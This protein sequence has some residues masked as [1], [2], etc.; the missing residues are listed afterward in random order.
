MLTIFLLDYK[1]N[2]IY[3]YGEVPVKFHCMI[4]TYFI[5]ILDVVLISLVIYTSMLFSKRARGNLVIVGMLV[6]SLFYL[7]AKNLELQLTYTVLKFFGGAAIVTLAIVFQ[8]EL[9]RYFELVGLISTRRLKNK[10]SVEETG[11]SAEIVQA[12]VQMAQEKI[13]ALIVVQGEDSIEQITKGGIVLDGVISEEILSSIFEPNT[14]GHDGAVLINQERIVRFGTQLPLSN[15][16]KEIGKHGTR[17]SAGLGLSERSDATVIIVSEEKGSIS[18]AHKGKLTKLNN[19]DQLEI[20]LNKRVNN[21][22][23]LKS[24]NMR[25][26]IFTHN[27]LYKVAAVASASIFKLL[28]VAA[29]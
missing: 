27:L 28:L 9:R 26:G 14:D 6:L 20:V 4:Y 1:F 5:F 3:S 11:A 10:N 16:F 2:E 23:K 29:K 19:Y 25:V 12:C 22:E 8:A 7:V 17:H 24:E 21:Q 15:N 13:G 18:I